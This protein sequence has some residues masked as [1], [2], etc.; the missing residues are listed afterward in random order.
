MRAKLTYANVVST[1]A[2]FLILGGVGIA[3]IP[4][5]DGKIH[6]CYQSGATAVGE[7]RIVDSET[8]CRGDESRLTFNQTGPQGPAGPRGA[9]GP[10]GETGGSGL[11][12]AQGDFGVV[13]PTIA[14]TLASVASTT[15]LISKLQRGRHKGQAERKL[16]KKL[17]AQLRTTTRELRKLKRQIPCRTCP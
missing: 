8:A 3:S 2:L 12:R 1:L 16:K 5:S 10:Q 9:T 4:G 17:T 14:A 6:G 13:G 11:G 7:F 15:V